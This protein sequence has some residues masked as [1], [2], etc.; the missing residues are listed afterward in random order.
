MKKIYADERLPYK[1]RKFPFEYKAISVSELNETQD[2]LP[3]EA[4]KPEEKKEKKDYK[5]PKL[6]R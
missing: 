4:T 3:I 6:P 1:Q 5:F 2:N